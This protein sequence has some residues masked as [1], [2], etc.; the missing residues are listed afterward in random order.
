[1]FVIQFDYSELSQLITKIVGEVLE[2]Q[3]KEEK[4]H[5]LISMAEA[6]SQIRSAN[7][8]KQK[9]YGSLRK[10]INSGEIRQIGRKVIQQDVTKFIQKS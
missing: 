2:R 10:L 9:S 7:I 3:R 8:P 6:L 1:M 5:R 4:E